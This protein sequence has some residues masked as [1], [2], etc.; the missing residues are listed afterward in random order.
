MIPKIIYNQPMRNMSDCR[1]RFSHCGRPFL[2]PVIYK[3]APAKRIAMS[4]SVFQASSHFHNASTDDVHLQWI[5][6]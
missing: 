2:S 1:V 5:L 6:L 4:G 3:S